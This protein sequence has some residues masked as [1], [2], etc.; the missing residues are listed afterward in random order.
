MHFVTPRY[1]PVT[2]FIIMHHQVVTGR[3]ANN[4]RQGYV[5]AWTI[6]QDGE[7]GIH[8]NGRLEIKIQLSSFEN[9]SI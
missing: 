3:Y 9:I 6:H 1:T 2:L 8:T 5:E 4:V 7:A